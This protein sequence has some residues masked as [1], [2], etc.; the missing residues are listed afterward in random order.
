M[1]LKNSL[2]TY[3]WLRLWRLFRNSEMPFNRGTFFVS[4]SDVEFFARSAIYRRVPLRPFLKACLLL[5][6]YPRVWLGIDAFFRGLTLYCIR[7]RDIGGFFHDG[8]VCSLAGLKLGEWAFLLWMSL[9]LIVRSSNVVPTL[10]YRFSWALIRTLGSF[11]V[12]W[13]TIPNSFPLVVCRCAVQIVLWL[14]LELVIFTSW[15]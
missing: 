11:T 12:V 3:L 10:R 6:P 7:L 9:Y 8:F 15:F 1:R 14:C 5:P 13:I 2:S 4:L